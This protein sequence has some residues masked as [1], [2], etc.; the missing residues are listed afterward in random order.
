MIPDSQI[1]KYYT[2]QKQYLVANGFWEMHT[3]NL[4]TTTN[5]MCTC[6]MTPTHLHLR[7]TSLI[8][9]ESSWKKK[10][11]IW[12]KPHAHLKYRCPVCCFLPPCALTLQK[13]KQCPGNENMQA[14]APLFV[15]LSRRMKTLRLPNH[16]RRRDL[17]DVRHVRRLGDFHVYVVRLTIGNVCSCDGFCR[18]L[19][20]RMRATQGV[21]L[22]VF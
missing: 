11:D 6:T 21:P 13:L 1:Q 3:K 9:S 16:Q 5:N 12:Q 4:T 18:I 19:P 7:H 20:A 2:Y 14:T 10:T 15:K 22:I 8:S 17:R